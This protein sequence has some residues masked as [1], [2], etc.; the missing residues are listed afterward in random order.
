MP[1]TSEPIVTNAFRQSVRWGPRKSRPTPEPPGWSVTN[2]FRQSV[3]WGLRH[4]EIERLFKEIGHQCLSAVSPLG[5]RHSRQPNCALRVVTNAFRQSVRW[6]PAA[7]P[8]LSP[9]NPGGHQCLS[10]VSPLGTRNKNMSTIYIVMSPMPF[11]SQSAG[12]HAP[13]R[14]TL[15]PKSLSPM[16]FGSQS[17]GDNPES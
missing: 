17:A 9:V 11:G 12:D 13:A 3:R 14:I 1:L 7:K 15:N 5:T 6:G 16:P 10:A 8:V 2:A 4:A